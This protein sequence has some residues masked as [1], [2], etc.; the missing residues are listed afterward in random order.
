MAWLVLILS[1]IMV[2]PM[3]LLVIEASL[4]KHFD[5]SILGAIMHGIKY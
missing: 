1:V 3:L 2:L 4:T 5:D